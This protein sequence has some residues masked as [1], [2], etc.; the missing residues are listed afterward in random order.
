MN[1]VEL[2]KAAASRARQIK[3]AKKREKRKNK[4]GKSNYVHKENTPRQRARAE[5]KL[6]KAQLLNDNLDPEQKNQLTQRLHTLSPN[7]FHGKGGQTKAKEVLGTVV[8]KA[9]LD[10]TSDLFLES[11]DWRD[12]RFNILKTYGSKCMCCGATPNHGAVMN[13][14]HIKPRKYYP[15]LALDKNNLQVLCNP[16]NHGKG[17]KDDASNDFRPDNWRGI[18]NESKYFS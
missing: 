3:D 11:F 7:N 5:R 15:D 18:L 2:E 4:R 16:C 13:V 6:I 8:K 12:L 10:P 1:N 14:D 17:N 9:P